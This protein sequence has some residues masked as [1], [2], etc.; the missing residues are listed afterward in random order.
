[1]SAKSKR[2]MRFRFRRRPWE[3]AAAAVIGLGIV[4]QMQPFALD[5]YTWSLAV[6]VAGTTGFVAASHLPE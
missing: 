4:M 1:M 3:N 6:I 2:P 5:L